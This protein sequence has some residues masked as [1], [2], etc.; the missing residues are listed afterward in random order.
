M[1]DQ[2]PATTAFNNLK[3]A[4]RDPMS[5]STA[6][7]KDRVAEALF[8]LEMEIIKYEPPILHHPDGPM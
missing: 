2:S 7:E 6:A 3:R 4:I 5:I 8:R 1:P